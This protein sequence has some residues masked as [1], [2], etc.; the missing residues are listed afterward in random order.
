MERDSSQ[1]DDAVRVEVKGPDPEV[2][3]E[4]RPL[5]PEPQGLA[6]GEVQNEGTEEEVKGP[7]QEWE[8]DDEGSYVNRD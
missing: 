1:I 8:T 7:G 2:W 3:G 5:P 4:D 6:V